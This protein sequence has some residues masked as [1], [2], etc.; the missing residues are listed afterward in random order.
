MND[1]VKEDGEV[2]SLP[3]VPEQTRHAQETPQTPA[4]ARVD[5]VALLTM[6][7]YERASTLVLDAQE[8]KTLTA[9]F[10][11][12][13]FKLGAGG[14]ADL[15]Y[16]EHHALRARFHSVFG[17]GAWSIIPRNRWTEE[18]RTSGG[19][20]AV[21]VYVEAMLLV[22]G[23]FVGEAIGDMTYFPD[24]ATTNFGDAIEG[25]KTAALRRCAK[26]FG[27]GLQAW[28]RDWVDG[29][30]KR[31]RT[32]QSLPPVEATP[33]KQPAQPKLI[34]ANQKDELENLAFLAGQ[35]LGDIC[36]A[37][38]IDNL[39]ELHEKNYPKLKA[40]LTSVKEVARWK[41][42]I[43]G[44]NTPESATEAIEEVAADKSLDG[45]PNARTEILEVLANH[46]KTQGWT[47]DEY[48]KRFVTDM[49]IPI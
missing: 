22:R 2:I 30:K 26:E 38:K 13:D 34:S 32:G 1:Q 19:K 48:T 7:A 43:E 35:E 14:K 16:L 24:N 12:D 46:A 20:Q 31:Q 37:C 49:E 47:W 21:R 44:I 18:Y 29:W 5:A 39:S 6:Q 41:E 10:P 25:A 11:D 40:H 45:L 42:L 28:N 27:V 4:Q 36:S 15:I 23:C 8:R 3:A 17:P 9:D 33:P